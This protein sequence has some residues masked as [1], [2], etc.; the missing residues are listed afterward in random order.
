MDAPSSTRTA[1]FRLVASKSRRQ[2]EFIA[3]AE[4]DF[5]GP[6]RGAIGQE[7]RLQKVLNKCLVDVR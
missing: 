1:S 7:L 4:Q 6:G 2:K 5:S 3:K